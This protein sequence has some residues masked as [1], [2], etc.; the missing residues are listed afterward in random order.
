MMLKNGCNRDYQVSLPITL[1]VELIK[2]AAL[3]KEYVNITE[4]HPS[5][6]RYPHPLILRFKYWRE[7]VKSL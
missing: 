4:S 3:M 1:F 7:Y 5:P 2:E 6:L